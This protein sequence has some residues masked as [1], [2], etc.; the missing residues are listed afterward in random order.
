MEAAILKSLSMNFLFCFIFIRH[1]IALKNLS[2]LWGVLRS[3]RF[4]MRD[5]AVSPDQVTT[6]TLLRGVRDLLDATGASKPD[7]PRKTFAF[8]NLFYGENTP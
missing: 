6:T 1:R 2:P 8:T 4:G 5:G 3:T 7:A